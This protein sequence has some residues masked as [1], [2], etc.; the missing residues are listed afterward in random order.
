MAEIDTII[1]LI[2]VRNIRAFC[3]VKLFTKSDDFRTVFGIHGTNWFADNFLVDSE[4]VYTLILLHLFA[5][6]YAQSPWRFCPYRKLSSVSVANFSVAVV[7]PFLESAAVVFPEVYL[8]LFYPEKHFLGSF[9]LHKFYLA[10]ISAH[11]VLD[12]DVF[13]VWA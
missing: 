12:N 4:V 11:W 10:C 5:I 9:T 13:L 8:G 6:D 2:V 3:C 7:K 1:I